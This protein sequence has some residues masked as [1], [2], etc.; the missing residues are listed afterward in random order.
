MFTII[1]LLFD[2]LVSFFGIYVFDYRID[3]VVNDP[4]VIILSILAG[5]FVFVLLFVLY[6][7]VFYLLVAK[8]LPKTSMTKHF[9]A[10]QIMSI[11]LFF[12]HTR[13][14]VIGMDNLPKDPGFS[15]YSNH[16]SMMD[17]PL[18]MYKLKKYPVAF[19]AKEV[20]ERIISVGKWTPTLGCV[21]ID[22]ENTRKGAESI[23][24]V[25]KNVKQGSTMVIFPEGTRSPNIGTTIDFKPGSFKVALKSKAPL[26]PMSI[27]KPLN[28][29][30]IK[31]PF[32][33]PITLVIHPPIPYEEYRKMTTQELSDNV[34][35]IIE[36]PLEGSSSNESMK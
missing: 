13:T 5:I 6:V 34:R 14:T 16:T 7:E 3:G 8:R 24:K 36:E 25:I 17:I 27:V 18:L 33:K 12:T 32:K 23:I 15:I 1:L 30:T 20:V 22:R 19:L 26:V 2:I 21:M 31:W 28:F 10:K 9:I 29:K 35:K 11:P 4:I